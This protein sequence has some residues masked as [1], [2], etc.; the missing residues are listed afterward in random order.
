MRS[1]FILGSLAFFALPS[2]A[3][4]ANLSVFPSSIELK[5]GDATEFVVRLQSQDSI[6][7]IGSRVLLPP[8]S[9]FLS[10]QDGDVLTQWVERPSYDK[11]DSS[12]SFSGIIPNGWKG[13]G[14]L[15]II[16]IAALKDGTY[17]LAF[18]KGNTEVYQNDGNATPEPVVFGPLHNT[19]NIILYAVLAALCIMVGV[20]LVRRKYKI[21]FI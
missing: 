6:N 16:K 15:V 14:T 18:D 13:E 17:S 3:F 2:A 21:I 11:K 12:V 1:I 19:G 4:A 8:N 10:A 9:T 5:M 20:V 7:T